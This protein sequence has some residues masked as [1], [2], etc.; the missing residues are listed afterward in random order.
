MSEK[1]KW[2]RK[3]DCLEM[4]WE[5]WKNQETVEEKE[6]GPSS[7]EGD[8]C[9]PLQDAF[10][11]SLATGSTEQL[12]WK[13]YIKR[14]PLTS[15]NP[16]T[17][18]STFLTNGTE[19]EDSFIHCLGGRKKKRTCQALIRAT[20]MKSDKLRTNCTCIKPANTPGGRACLSN[21]VTYWRERHK[22]SGEKR[23]LKSSKFKPNRAASPCLYYQKNWPLRNTELF[24]FP[25]KN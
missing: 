7:S 20:G 3:Q 17:Q 24:Q 19:T 11:S 9:Q 15:P 2:L 18:F 12:A 16:C 10:L 21:G 13:K 1:S 8:S 14:S 25:H 23:I 6:P 5:E 22:G 4:D